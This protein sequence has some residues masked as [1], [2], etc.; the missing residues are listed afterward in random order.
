M[1]SIISY[2]VSRVHIL[3]VAFKYETCVTVWV[4][5]FQCYELHR[6]LF[7]NRACLTVLQDNEVILNTDTKSV[8]S[9]NQPHLHVQKVL[10]TGK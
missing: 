9:P 6:V 10:F 5:C 4:L 2:H 8:L 3:K 1:M 7:L